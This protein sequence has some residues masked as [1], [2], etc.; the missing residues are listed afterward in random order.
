MEIKQNNKEIIFSIDPA[1]VIAKLIEKYG[2][3]ESMEEFLERVE[4]GEVTIG[5]KIAEIIK[6]VI[7]GEIS[8]KDLVSVFQQRLKISKEIA[9][10]LAI[11]I[12]KEILAFIQKV[13]EKEEE[14]LP[15]KVP[16]EKPETKP[17]IPP[18]EPTS[19]KKD[20]YR[21]PIE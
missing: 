13:P 7:D 5:E 1:E 18:E 14:V 4:K 6:G 2:L 3:G 19:K 17:G 21:E 20:F 10:K 12:E 16:I 11:D 15:K 9:E 8:K